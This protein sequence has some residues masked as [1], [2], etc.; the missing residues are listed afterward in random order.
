MARSNGCPMCISFTTTGQLPI[1][2]VPLPEIAKVKHQSDMNLLAI[3]DLEEEEEED[4]LLDVDKDD[5]AQNNLSAQDKPRTQA[6]D[7]QGL[8]PEEKKELKKYPP[9]WSDEIVDQLISM[10]EANMYLGANLK[11]VQINGKACLIRT[12]LSLDEVVD[13]R[14]R[15]NRE[16]MSK[17]LAPLDA[18]GD[19]VELHHI[20]QKSN[21]GLAELTNAEHHKGGN[22][23]V[24]HDKKKVSEIDRKEFDGERKKHWETRAGSS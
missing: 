24:L 15:T 16:R 6:K 5:K 9:A 10:D 2:A 11:E 1:P 23:T 17:G 21:A 19:S 14:G 20:G 12:D 4:E 18:N 13:D 22:D 7:A 8:T 3:D